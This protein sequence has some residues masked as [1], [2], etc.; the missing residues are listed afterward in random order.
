MASIR[1]AEIIAG[2][3]NNVADFDPLDLPDWAAGWVDADAAGL[4]PGMI[5]QGGGVFAYPPQPPR[6][7]DPVIEALEM[8]VAELP[9]GRRARIAAKV[10]KAK[11]RRGA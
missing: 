5:D 10:A 6:A 7:P 2:K 1:L 11:A 4:H 3:V 8:L 9:A